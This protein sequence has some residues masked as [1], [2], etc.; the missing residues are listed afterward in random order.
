M[1]ADGQAAILPG[2]HAAVGSARTD[3]KA[4]MAG[5]HPP[6]RPTFLL[7]FSKHIFGYKQFLWAARSKVGSHLLCKCYT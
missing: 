3:G 6:L 1:G 2:I 5:I 7:D 4:V